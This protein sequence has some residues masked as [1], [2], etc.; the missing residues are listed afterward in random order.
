M[1]LGFTAQLSRSV[2]VAAILLM[3]A[4]VMIDTVQ[5]FG[6]GVLAVSRREVM[7]NIL[8]MTSPISSLSSSSPEI[9]ETIV[10]EEEGKATMYAMDSS[11][12]TTDQHDE[13]SLDDDQS[14]A[15]LRASGE[16]DNPFVSRRLPNDHFSLS[17]DVSPMSP[18][19]T[20]QK[21]LTMQSRRV[22]VAIRYSA[23]SGMKPYFLTVAKK[24]KDSHPDI[25]LDKVILPKIMPTGDGKPEVSPTFEVMVDGKVIIPTVGKKDRI[26]SG[27][28]AGKIVFV[29][30]EELDTAISRARR[31]RRPSTVYGD[32]EGNARLEMLKA[33]AAAKFAQSFE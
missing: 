19:L 16:T 6:V 1:T 4:V 30:M 22:P 24:L 21:F 9:E 32:D 12:S 11:S 2:A 27:G 26:G 17:E 31:R 8:S 10:E 5:A 15:A 25:I 7:S 18:P 13:K 3:M 28:S 23:D 14:A 33:K 20:Y 29:S